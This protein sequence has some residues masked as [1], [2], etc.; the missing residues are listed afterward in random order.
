MKKIIVAV[1]LMLTP[2][3]GFS[4]LWLLNGNFSLRY[5]DVDEGNNFELERFYN[6]LSISKGAFGYGWGSHFETRLSVVDGPFVM[7]EE[8]PGGGRS[9]YIAKGSASLSQLADKYLKATNAINNGKDYVNRLRT[10]LLKEPT[11]LFEYAKRYKIFGTVKEGTV[12][13]CVER[14]GEI[15]KKIKGGY[16]RIGSDGVTDQFDSEGRIIKRIAKTGRGFVFSYTANG[17]LQTVRDSLGRSMNFFFNAKGF[18]ERVSL[19]NGKAAMYSY[20]DNDNLS[21]STDSGGNTYKY[22]YDSYHRVIEITLPSGMAGAKTQK[23][24]IGYDTETGKVIYQ[25]TPQGW[26]IF[27]EYANDKSKNQ[28]YESVSIVKKFGNEV[29]SEKYEFWKRPDPEGSLY[30]YKTRQKIGKKEKTVTYTMCCGTPLVVNENGKITRFE[31]NKDGKLKKK[32]LPDGRIVD[33]KYEDKKHVSSIINNGDPYV[34]KYN[35]K[36]Q[37]TLAASRDLKFKLSYDGNGN[38]ANIVD[39]KNNSFS[40]KYDERGKLKEVSSKDAAMVVQYADNGAPIVMPKDKN[41]DTDKLWSIRKIYLDYIEM[42]SVFGL[43]EVE[44]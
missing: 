40:F 11:L 19:Y 34:F 2:L 13:E 36:D 3:S 31:Y 1:I 25:K 43:I 28:Y 20:D 15:L 14:A 44:D 4:T 8:V 16:T 9:H 37:I 24:N 5:T 41:D 38:V 35:D 22:K 6:S 32:V 27:T 30:T 7:I 17:K 10:T 42:M 18:I 12:L 23:W 26:E 39:N 33:V 21:Q 29:I